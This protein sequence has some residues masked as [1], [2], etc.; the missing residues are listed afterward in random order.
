[1]GRRVY[2]ARVWEGYFLYSRLSH[3]PPLTGR[4][5]RQWK[6]AQQVPKGAEGGG[7]AEGAVRQAGLGAAGWKEC[8]G[9]K[10][11]GPG[12]VTALSNAEG[13]PCDEIMLNNLLFRPIYHPLLSSSPSPQDLDLQAW[14]PEEP[15]RS[16]SQAGGGPSRIHSGDGRR[17]GGGGAAGGGGGGGSETG[18]GAG[19][20]RGS[21]AQS[22]SRGASGASATA[23]AA[24]AGDAV[25]AGQG[26]G[27]SSGDG[28][29]GAPPV[30]RSGS[31]GGAAGGAGAAS[32]PSV[33]SLE[34]G[35]SASKSSWVKI[36][37]LWRRD[38]NGAAAGAAGEKSDLG[39]PA[40]GGGGGRAGGRGGEGA[41][42]SD[43]E[44]DAHLEVSSSRQAVRPEDD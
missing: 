40:A 23:A 13:R 5:C 22:P 43:D 1:M 8:R 30:Y 2:L 15:P 21:R 41:G 42:S 27:I 35:A 17:S 6:N 44:A 10:Q 29:Q 11:R 14:D 32:L 19:S 18:G 4:D 3:S 16:S 25:G 38:K 31:G 24:G 7:G 37:T 39:K 36:G 20:R 12:G 28:P 9:G 26:A 34:R 33:P